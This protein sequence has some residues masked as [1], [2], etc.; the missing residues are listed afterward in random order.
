[1]HNLRSRV[2]WSRRIAGPMALFATLVVAPAA[3]AHTVLVGSNPAVDSTVTSLPSKLTLTFADNLLQ[4]SGKVLNSVSVTDSMKMEIASNAV[5][6]GNTLTA[7]LKETMA[8]TGAFTVNYRV[9]ALDGHVVTGKYVFT[10]GTKAAASPTIA[11][12]SSGSQNLVANLSGSLAGVKNSTASGIAHLA[13]NFSTKQVCYTVSETGLSGIT[14]MHVHP[15]MQ[16]SSMNMT[17]SDEVFI[18]LNNS[19]VNATSP[20]CTSVKPLMMAEIVANPSHY[21]VMIH[22][23]DHPDGAVAGWLKK[24]N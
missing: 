2:N 7:D 20:V 13:F 4:V 9:V 14:A 5:V 1:M 19:A 24:S 6:K 22:T 17:V 23:K 12:P 15:M 3:V 18:L 11:I 8:M 16:G 21:A 10:V